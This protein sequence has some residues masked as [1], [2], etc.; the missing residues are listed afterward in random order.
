MRI[1]RDVNPIVDKIINKQK[2]DPHT[3]YRFL[4]YCVITNYQDSVLIYN[5]MT[6]ALIEI[7][8]EEF[9]CISTK[10]FT[11][12]KAFYIENWF[13]VP[14]EHNDKKLQDQLVNIAKI[15]SK[16]DAIS[17][18]VILTTTDCNARCFYCYEHGTP[19]RKMTEQT[20]RDVAEFI[21]KNAKNSFVWLRWFGGEPLYN[22][23]PINIISRFLKN[24]QIKF[25]SNIVTNG[26]LF[27]DSAIKNAKE[28]WNLKMAQITIDGTEKIYNR[29]KNY[30]YG[31]VESPYKIIMQNIEN[32][33]RNEIKV[34][35]RLNLG[36]HNMDD[37]YQLI[38]G[39]VEKFKDNKF[40]KIAISPLAEN[41]AGIGVRT[42]EDQLRVYNKLFEFEDYIAAKNVLYSSTL[43]SEIS[44][45]ACLADNPQGVL[46]NPDGGISKCDNYIFEHLVGD[47]KSGV[48]D[49]NELSSW[50]EY[51]DH[52]Q[53]CEDCPRY[54]TCKWVKRCP[55]MKN[56][57]CNDIQKKDYLRILKRNVIETFKSLN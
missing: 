52:I 49:G 56:R 10:E 14:C 15:F 8:Q 5:N 4:H 48:I 13:L 3:E 18:Y 40:Y 2:I 30:I 16:N 42:K 55:A 54:P 45:Y 51:V 27:S 26:Y 24:K 47:I 33:I 57:V 31:N 41:T 39:L 46:I 7:T 38:D 23:E 20:A 36:D 44:V 9:K 21:A 32:L 17:T 53:L 28:L 22:I 11:P 19:K 34:V 1:V 25:A 6:K 50:R 12:E 35:I 29:C 43:S 37:L